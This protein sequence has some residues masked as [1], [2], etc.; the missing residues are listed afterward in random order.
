MSNLGINLAQGRTQAGRDL[1]NQVGNVAQLLGGIQQG[2]ATNLS[3]LTQG[4]M[5]YLNSLTNNAAAAE[6]MA[7]QGYSGNQA[8]LL[9]GTGSTMLGI[10]NVP[11]FVPDY[12]AMVGNALDA[13]SV[14]YDMFKNQNTNQAGSGSGQGFYMQPTQTGMNYNPALYASQNLRGIA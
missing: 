5:N 8:N 6:A 9:T 13:G 11:S 1:A 4:Q 7:Q 10:G 12:G 2:Q 3:N 14:G